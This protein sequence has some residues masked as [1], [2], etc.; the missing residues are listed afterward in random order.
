MKVRLEKSKTDPFRAG[1]DV[2]VIIAQSR[3]IE[4]VR[5]Y[6]AGR[7]ELTSNG[8]LFRSEAG[9]ALDVRALVAYTRSV[10]V[11]VL[12][13]ERAGVPEL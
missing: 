6:L 9:S 2:H 5:A 8:P 12:A 7:V 10:H 13:L 1:A 4:A 3:A 11:R